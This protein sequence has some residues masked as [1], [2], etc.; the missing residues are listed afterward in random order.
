MSFIN[1]LIQEMNSVPLY[2]QTDEQTGEKF[3]TIRCDT[4]C[5]II[6]VL[7]A[8]YNLEEKIDDDLS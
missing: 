3:K 4:M 7:L 2:S 8:K 1:D 6:T 5:D